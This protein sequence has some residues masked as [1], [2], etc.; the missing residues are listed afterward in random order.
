MGCASA[1]SPRNHAEAPA[2]AEAQV[3]DQQP[4]Q[5][6]Q[7]A[8]T[9]VTKRP[10]L[11]SNPDRSQ[12]RCGSKERLQAEIQASKVSAETILAEVDA[13]AESGDW[14]SAEQALMQALQ[15]AAGAAPSLWEKIKAAPSVREACFRSERMLAAKMSLASTDSGSATWR[16]GP[17]VPID[18]RKLCPSAPEATWQGISASV[19]TRWRCSNEGVKLQIVAELPP[20]HPI[21]KVPF[22]QG[23]LAMFS[24]VDMMHK[25]YPLVSTKYP[26]N[27]HS[28]TIDQTVYDERI[29]VRFF[30][31]EQGLL[32]VHRF[33]LPEGIYLQR[34]QWVINAADERL[35]K[36]QKVPGYKMKDEA[37]MH[38]LIIVFGS[39]KSVVI[40][41]Q[42]NYLKSPPSAWLVDK[43]ISWILPFM[44]RKQISIGAGIFEDKDYGD[45]MQDDDMGF[46][47]RIREC[48]ELGKRREA[49]GGGIY[50]I[51]AGGKRPIP[52][53]LGS[54][55]QLGAFI[56]DLEKTIAAR[57]L[58][59][60]EPGTPVSL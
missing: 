46:Y 9:A 52:E 29:D 4:E 40:I 38:S 3:V 47:G 43:L 48:Y 58:G 2:H 30:S 5:A 45:R 49:T 13:C 27:I 14:F 16:P 57:Q 31:H 26:L 60:G 8:D 41:T 32:E 17:S 18:W 25:W 39:K 44:I 22:A 50:S 20:E 35:K 36:M 34:T 23:L 37:D 54:A 19:E 56:D 51:A 28:K 55:G 15:G 11:R 12:S 42:E 21:Q 53:D 59:P 6:P 1:K 24:E 10:S 33:F 7:E